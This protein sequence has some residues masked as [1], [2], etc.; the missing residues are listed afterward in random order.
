MLTTLTDPSVKN[1]D[2]NL[3]VARK[4]NR[5]IVIKLDRSALLWDYCSR[6]GLWDIL[7]GHL[8]GVNHNPQQCQ[9]DSGKGVL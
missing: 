9:S 3:I 7:F 5:I 1:L 8:E 2:Q 4:S 6:L